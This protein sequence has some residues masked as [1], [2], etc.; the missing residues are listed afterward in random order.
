MKPI[1]TYSASFLLWLYLCLALPYVGI[2]QDS[3]PENPVHTIHIVPQSHIDIVWLWRYDPETIHR[4]CKITY[5]QALDNMDRYP[6]FTFSQSQVPLF[7]PV[8]NIYPDIYRRIK[9][10]IRQGRWE[11]AGGMYVEPEGGEPNG[12]SWVRQCVMG[13][14]W[15]QKKFDLDISTGWQP[16]AWGHPSQ[17]P[18]IMA[19]SG[20]K[21]YLWRR[22]DAGGPRSDVSEKL[23]WWQAPD[24]SK[25]L[26]YRFPDPENPPYPEWKKDVSISKEKYKLNDTMI[27]IG[28]GD[29]GG[30]P[31]GKDIETT[32]DFANSLPAGYKAKFSS[33]Q[34]YVQSVLK[35]NPQLPVIQD[36]LG[37]E[38]RGDLT[39]VCE[40]KKGNREGE[41]LLL[42]T[43]KWAAI[44]SQWFAFEYPREEF[45]D[46]WKK[47]LFNQ[48]HDILGGSLIPEAIGDAMQYYQSVRDSGNYITGAAIKS[49]AKSINTEGEGQLVVVFNPLS[50][51][52][53]DIVE[54]TLEFPKLPD[55]LILKD[56][57]GKTFPLQIIEQK[58]TKGKF[59]IR[60]LFIAPDVPSLGYKTFFV[61]ESKNSPLPPN[62]LSVTENKLENEFFLI[63]IDSLTGCIKRLFDKKN[64]RELFKEAGEGNDLVAIEDEGDSEGR[65][66]LRS[67]VIGK[68]PGKEEKIH[69]LTQI[70]ILETGPVRAK[71]QVEKKY[72]N[73]ILSQDII[74]YPGIGRVD[75]NLSMDWHGTERMIKLAFPFAL[76]NPTV[77]YDIPYGAMT[78]PA[79]GMEYPAQ[80]WIDL[81]SGDYGIS[82]MNNGRYGHDVQGNTVRMSILRS[83]THPAYNTDEGKHTLGYSL[84]PH[85]NSWKESPVM[86]KGYD[87]NNPLFALAT[88]SQPGTSPKEKSFISVQPENI[89][90]EVVK[91]AY[92]SGQT[93]LRLCEMNGQTSKTSITFPA[94]IQ[95][96][97]ETDLLENEIS[98]LNTTGNVLEFSMKP[99]EI[100][101]LKV[102]FN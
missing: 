71:I 46:A 63:E 56:S 58:N 91:K 86:Q 3:I 57:Q 74:L 53:S 97:Q 36:E 51:K 95:S 99:Y 11:I 45:E 35:Q 25:V 10:Y 87:F 21:S 40:I 84:F 102:S 75:F 67:D 52:R 38:L 55:N 43:E 62:S 70:R 69:A 73:S 48:F 72:Q 77:T 100:K 89:I 61:V 50:W 7:E 2:S 16:D 92:D 29:H 81:A 12:E 15:F 64:N 90:L 17:L 4:C 28:W 8:E 1:L 96:V 19:K 66:V 78:R 30:G 23:F 47:L 42:S 5:T 85:K 76:D 27:V 59:L 44:A 54:T 101:T 26:A 98:R 93:V 60:C 82:L 18:Q 9:E 49:I 13:K 94:E 32:Q 37:F 34:G 14:R 65:F 22:G 31:S 39:N 83:P 41:N 79:D 24:G 6:E 88:V 80:K 68:P 33:F 20:I